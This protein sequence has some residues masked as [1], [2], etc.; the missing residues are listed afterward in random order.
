MIRNVFFLYN[1]AL[2]SME[3]KHVEINNRTHNIKVHFIK[4]ASKT[5]PLA[6]N[7]EVGSYAI[8]AV[9]PSQTLPALQD[10]CHDSCRFL[11]QPASQ[12]YILLHLLLVCCCSRVAPQRPRQKARG[13]ALHRG[14]ALS[15]PFAG[16]HRL[17]AWERHE[18]LSFKHSTWVK[19]IQRWAGD[20]CAEV[21]HQAL[22]PEGS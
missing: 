3:S 1:Y 19:F 16:G 22:E 4:C 6:C 9:V 11:L 20:V 12:S 5:R 13:E 7:G 10:R 15:R 8:P 14:A 21:T 17:R 2:M 18:D